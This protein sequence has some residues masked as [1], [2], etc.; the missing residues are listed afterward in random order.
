MIVPLNLESINAQIVCLTQL[1]ASARYVSERLS[2]YRGQLQAAWSGDEAKMYRR[3]A[4]ELVRQ[5]ETLE[6]QLTVLRDEIV[7]V[8]E[9]IAVEESALLL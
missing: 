9:K 4:A 6:R 2:V 3:A 7:Q 5:S 8:M 1:A